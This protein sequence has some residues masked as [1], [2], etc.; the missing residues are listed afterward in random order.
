[1][2]KNYSLK[3]I[4][5]A[6][7]YVPEDPTY[8]M[9]TS[10]MARYPEVELWDFIENRPDLEY[11]KFSEETGANLTETHNAEDWFIGN[12]PINNKYRRFRIYFRIKLFCAGAQNKKTD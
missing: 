5:T 10:R 8:Y 4:V 7:G 9:E 11:I 12:F 2:D 1:M 6:N 3:D